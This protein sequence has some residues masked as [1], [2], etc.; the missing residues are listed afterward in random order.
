M[1]GG[2]GKRFW[3]LSRADKPKQLVELSGGK[4]LL[5][6]TVE[7]LAPLFDPEHIIV[8]TQKRQ[9]D[10]TSRVLERFGGLRVM[11]EPVG[12]NTAAC[13]T[14]A[15]T[16]IK[17]SHGD[18]VFSVLPADHFIEK[19]D[20]FRSLLDAGMNFVAERNALLTI[21]IKPDRPATGF[22]YIRKGKLAAEAGGLKFHEVSEFAEKPA[23]YLAEKYMASGEYLWNAGIFVFKASTI[24]AEIERFLPRMA[25][26]F[27]A[28]EAG[29]GT[30][31]EAAGIAG[32]YSR[33][34][35]ISIDFGVMEKTGSAFVV[36]ADIG[37]DDV[38][39]W[40]SFSRHM[41][42]DPD[43]NAVHGR[44]V[45]IGSRDCIV[46]SDSLTVATAGLKGI[47]IIVSEDAVLVIPRDK[48]EEV[49]DITDLLE[50]EGLTDL[51]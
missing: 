7:R 50:R 1:A 22:G 40:E 3:P 33:V 48:G 30:P 25:A 41:D 24:L 38:G 17:A 15:A 36:P 43:G 39:S 13:I 26:E 46:Y 11:A 5:E 44:H 14:Y 20:D 45:T 47:A 6:L 23:A 16:C 42:R 34:E 4:T 2:R 29:I 28:C 49:R 35:D 31:G 18:A 21:G 19:V 8:V 51:L 12:K 27:K 10:E 9:F 37:W 32:C